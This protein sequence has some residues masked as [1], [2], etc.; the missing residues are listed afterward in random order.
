[1]VSNLSEMRPWNRLLFRYAC[2]LFTYACW[3]ALLVTG[4]PLVLAVWLSIEIALQLAGAPAFVTAVRELR[5]D[6][7]KGESE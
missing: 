1:M 5:D 6:C 3:F 4:H 7:E 2:T